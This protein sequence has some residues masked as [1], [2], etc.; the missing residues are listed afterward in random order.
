MAEE[1]KPTDGL[2]F[3]LPD[4]LCI[5]IFFYRGYTLEVGGELASV[6]GFAWLKPLTPI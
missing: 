5:P 3:E 1:P 4:Y 6:A 2:L